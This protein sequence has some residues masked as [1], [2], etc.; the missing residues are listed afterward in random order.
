MNNIDNKDYQDKVAENI[1][2]ANTLFQLSKEAQKKILTLLEKKE[3]IKQKNGLFASIQLAH[4]DKKINKIKSK[5]K[6]KKG[7]I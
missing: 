1:F 5:E 7:N 6:Q 3:L 2:I 4:I